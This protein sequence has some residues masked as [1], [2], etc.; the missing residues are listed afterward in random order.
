MLQKLFSMLAAILAYSSAEA[1][2]TA[3]QLKELY[4]QPSPFLSIPHTEW[5]AES[6]N[7]FVIRTNN[8]Q[9]PIH[10]LIIPKKQIPSLLEAPDT[11]V[12]EMI[13]LA[14]RMAKKQGIAD[15]GFRLIINT[16]PYGG[17][18]VYHLHMHL[19]GGRELGWSPGFREEG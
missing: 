4:A 8:P 12:A 19:L 11:L 16:H 18:S 2:I 17:Q 1:Q 13:S 7:A 14:K 15:D 6:K 10:L 9:A 5:V 3:D